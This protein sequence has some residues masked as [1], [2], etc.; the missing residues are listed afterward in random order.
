MSH[1]N[2]SPVRVFVR[3]YCDECITVHWME[4]ITRHRL[5]C[6]GRHFIPKNSE[7][8]YT[9]WRYGTIELIEKAHSAP[10]VTDWMFAEVERLEREHPEEFQDW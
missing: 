9:R 6:H 3:Q 7:T 1:S 4:E 10:D 8:H 5:T 2:P